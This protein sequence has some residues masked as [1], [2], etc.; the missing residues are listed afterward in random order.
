M[1]RWK[2]VLLDAAV[3]KDAGRYLTVTQSSMQPTFAAPAGDGS[4]H[5]VRIESIEELNPNSR[6]RPRGL[7]KDLGLVM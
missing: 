6:S 2:H 3:S 5:R 1:S 4:C 7:M